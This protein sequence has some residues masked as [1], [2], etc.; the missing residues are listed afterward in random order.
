[1]QGVY[2]ALSSAAY[3]IHFNTPAADSPGGFSLLGA[4]ALV[5]YEVNLATSILV[6]VV[7]S[8][9]LIPES[10]KSSCT[11]N[12]NVNANLFRIP[13]ENAEMMENCP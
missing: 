1:M 10:M 4:A 11:A 9:V 6:T 12:C 5:L 13:I 7:V 2:F 8:V 3:F